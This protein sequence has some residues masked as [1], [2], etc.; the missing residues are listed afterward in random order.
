MPTYEYECTKCQQ[1][2]EEFQS[3]VARPLKK[4]KTD[5]DRCGN[6]APVKRLIGTGSAV[7]FKGS[8]FYETD[9]RSDSYKKDAE[10]AA[11]ST[12]SKSKEKSATDPSEKKPKATDSSVAKVDEKKKTESKTKDK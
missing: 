8:G 2:F 5:C 4:I 7:I 6:N 1:R 3:I 10:A 9:Y 12:T 11:D